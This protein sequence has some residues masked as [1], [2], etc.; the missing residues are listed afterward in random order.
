M[1]LTYQ[2]SVSKGWEYI[3]MEVRFQKQRQHSI[4]AVIQKFWIQILAFP[5]TLRVVK[6]Y[7]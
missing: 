4:L 2:H 6:N 7:I 3:V 5:L 1:L